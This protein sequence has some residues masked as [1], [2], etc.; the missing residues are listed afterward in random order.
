MK[1]LIVSDI[2]GRNTWKQEV[3]NALLN[4]VDKIIFLG[5]YVDSFDIN[6]VGIIHNLK[7][8]IEF[9]KKYNDKVVLL[10]GNHDVSY[11]FRFSNISGYNFMYKDEYYEIFKNNWDLFDI[12]WGYMN[13][14]FKYTLI[15]HAGLCKHF[16]KWE[17][18]ESIN[19]PKR[20]IH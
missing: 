3:N 2:H 7:E 19:T 1:I 17:I 4:F 5:D 12:A 15:T 20:Y 18:L 10:L 14:K 16:W 8:I 13:D 11:Y 9:K 6:P